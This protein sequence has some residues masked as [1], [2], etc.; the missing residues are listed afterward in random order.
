[1][2]L[3][4]LHLIEQLKTTKR[5]GWIN[6][7]IAN[8]ES[9]ADHMYRM[10]IICL[11]CTD[12]SLDRSKLVNLALVHD[13]AESLVGDITPLDNIPKHEKE[14]R[15]LLAMQAIRDEYGLSPAQGDEFMALFMEYE[16]KQTAESRFVKDVDKYELV[17]QTIEYEKRLGGAKDLTHFA[18]SSEMIQHPC[19][20][21]W[22]EEALRERETFWAGVGVARGRERENGFAE[23]V[24]KM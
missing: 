1:M 8:P 16:A 10:S 11:L 6:E 21:A 9:I 17:L 15:E 23:E 12:A 5:K 19:V 3:A 22:C 7:D 14:E 13:M 4:F 20:K 2:V 24:E 18:A